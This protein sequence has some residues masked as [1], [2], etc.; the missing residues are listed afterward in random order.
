MI[1]LIGGAMASDWPYSCL[2]ATNAS[3]I[4]QGLDATGKVVVIT[5]GDGS[6]GQ[7]ISVN[8]ARTNATTVLACHNETNCQTA[9]ASLQAELQL[10]G[11]VGIFDTLNIDLSDFDSVRTASSKLLSKYPAIDVLVNNAACKSCDYLTVDGLQVGMQTNHYGHALFTNLLLPALITDTGTSR[12]VS[13]TS[14]SGLGPFV[15]QDGI[16]SLKYTSLQ[17]IADVWSRNVSSLSANMFYSVSKFLIT[18]YNK[19]FAKRYDGQV[20]SFATAP[21]YAQEPVTEADLTECKTRGT[22][23]DPCPMSFEQGAT[24]EVLA[25]LYPDIEAYSGAYLDFDTNYY[26][27]GQVYEWTQNDPSCQPRSLPG[28]LGT[29]GTNVIWSDDDRSEWYDIVQELIGS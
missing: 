16:T 27:N 6:I 24:V 19:E 13:V 2:A 17:E 18:Q 26:P 11:K 28:W 3:E 10:E 5:G 9:V 8:V 20:V 12:V 25:A 14:V 15:E 4:V 21:G 1:S 7:H 23:F 29:D 22:N